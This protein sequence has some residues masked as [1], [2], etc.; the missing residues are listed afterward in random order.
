MKIVEINTVDYGSTGRIMLQ[1]AQQ[2]REDGHEAWTFSMARK[3]KVEP[4]IGHEYYCS[5]FSYCLHYLFGKM[6]GCNGLFSVMPTLRLIKRLRLI[7]PDII[8]L[9]NLHGFSINLPLLFQYLKSSG[10]HV[11][12]TLHDCWAFTGHCAHYDSVKCEKWKTGCK[13]CPIYRGYPESNVDNSKWMWKLK[14]KWFSGLKNVMLVTPSEWLADQAKASFLQDYPVCTLNNGIDLGVFK[15]VASN[16]K[17]RYHISYE[18]YVILGVAFGWGHKKGLDVFIHLAESLGEQYQVVLVGTDVDIE[19]TL[20][21]NILPIRRTESQQ[22]LAEIYSMADV[23]VNATREET[24]PTVNI[25]ALACGTPVIT[26]ETGGSPEILDATC[27]IIV[28][29]DDVTALKEAIVHIAENK[30]FTA[31]RCVERAK[32]YDMNDK[33]SEYVGLYMKWRQNE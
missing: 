15:P 21:T 1:I 4:R 7:Q 30:P 12:W 16:V 20:P 24:F 14:K 11:V 33:F 9:H 27:G 18:K 23:F 13:D 6:T 3:G 8:H 31:E 17:E 10:K 19:R 5:Y 28:P 22:E 29:C 26:F 2:A 25:E 32:R